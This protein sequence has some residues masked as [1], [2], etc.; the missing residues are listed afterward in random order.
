MAQASVCMRSILLDQSTTSTHFSLL[1]T[2]QH[3]QHPR[4]HTLA[5]ALSVEGRR[6]ASSES[7]AQRSPEREFESRANHLSSL[8]F[9]RQSRNSCRLTS[10]RHFP[11]GRRARA[12]RSGYLEKKQHGGGDDEAPVQSSLSLSTPIPIKRSRSTLITSC[13]AADS[14]SSTGTAG[15]PT[16][17][18]P[19][20][21]DGWPKVPPVGQTPL[22][23]P[24]REEWAPRDVASKA[25][26]AFKKGLE[27]KDW[28]EYLDMMTDD[29]E[30][31]VP[32]E[33]FL[34]KPNKG[35]EAMKTFF[36]L[37]DR[38]FSDLKM[39][40]ANRSFSLAL[41]STVTDNSKANTTKTTSKSAS[42]STPSSNAG[43][44][45]DKGDGGGDGEGHETEKVV[46]GTAMFEIRTSGNFANG[47]KYGNRIVVVVDVRGNQITAHREYFG[48]R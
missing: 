29:V 22:I 36:D 14:S 39:E 38:T 6:S 12:R 37:A 23:I 30:L 24:M 34:G 48:L 2:G 21:G 35:K 15:W 19:A 27:K 42:R 10:P 9:E 13:A 16:P 5:H 46:K 8:G 44:D 1:T 45:D 18:S 43:G 4:L 41:L 3:A 7:F 33:G 20:P 32:V 26:M 47:L 31:W 17:G 28:K 11:A 40:I 25:M